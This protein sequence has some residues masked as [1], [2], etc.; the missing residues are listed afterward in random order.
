MKEIFSS[1]RLERIDL[2]NSF[3]QGNDFRLA[4]SFA[5]QTSFT[6][7]GVRKAPRPLT[8]RRLSK[9]TALV[10]SHLPRAQRRRPHQ[11]GLLLG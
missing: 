3:R 2:A 6:H 11:Q 8:S 4:T 7:T 5:R 9:E 10:N 1:R